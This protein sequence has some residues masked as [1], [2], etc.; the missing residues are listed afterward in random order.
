[1][2]FRNVGL[3]QQIFKI[4][5]EKRGKSFDLHDKMFQNKRQNKKQQNKG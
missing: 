4:I 5:Q 2:K 3:P 1:M